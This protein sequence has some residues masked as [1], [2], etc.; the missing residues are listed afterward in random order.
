MTSL[1]DMTAVDALRWLDSVETPGTRTGE[2]RVASVLVL[3]DAGE[4]ETSV[5]AHWAGTSHLIAE[6]KAC[7]E[8]GVPVPGF[9]Y[10]R[11]LLIGASAYCDDP[12]NREEWA[13][14]AGLIERH[15]RAGAWAKGSAW[16]E[17]KR[18]S[19]V[20]GFEP[21]EIVEGFIAAGRGP[22]Y[23]RRIIASAAAHGS[24]IDAFGYDVDPVTYEDLAAAGIFFAEDYAV[25]RDAGLTVPEIVKMREAQVSPR[26]AR[27]ATMEGIPVDQWIER[28]ANIPDDW[29]P[30][31]EDGVSKGRGGSM[32][33]DTLKAAA[34][35]GWTDIPY[36]GITWGSGRR[37][38]GSMA[39]DDTAAREMIRLGLT[40]DDVERWGGAL[41]IGKAPR[42]G[43]SFD[44]SLAPI[45]RT[46]GVDDLPAVARL[47]GMG[48]RPSHVTEFRSIGCR[49]VADIV[50]AVHNGID[51]REAKRLRETHA[52]PRNSWNPKRIDRLT[53][54]I[55]LHNNDK[56][57]S[58]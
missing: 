56:E 27:R 12:E 37:S 9:D 44:T 45:L 51:G 53:E 47:R 20:G 55:R 8:R 4:H 26:M 32:S 40:P 5:L 2:I 49:S 43:D 16:A 52:K 41:C 15:N 13:A 19:L 48:V 28:L 6:V 1:R 35:A 54:A 39:L 46:M 3:V 21:R 17:S 14:V 30:V 29:G 10:G 50:T 58:A 34:D 7:T 25:F 57:Q 36:G 42:R 22:S 38:R 33:I 31:R 11:L 23:A 24:D 18:R